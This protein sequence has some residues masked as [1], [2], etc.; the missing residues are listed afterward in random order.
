MGALSTVSFVLLVSGATT[1]L[2][3][4]IIWIGLPALAATLAAAHG[5]AALTRHLLAWQGTQIPPPA[6]IHTNPLTGAVQAS[7]VRWIRR[8]WTSPQRWRELLHGIVVFPLG[9]AGF[10][11]AICTWTLGLGEMLA[12]VW[13]P[14][15]QS[16]DPGSVTTLGGGIVHGF[17]GAGV[18]AS[19]A[20]GSST[21]TASIGFWA[22]VVD[23]VIGAGLLALTPL[24]LDGFAKLTG[25]LGKA[26]LGAAPF[27]LARRVR[28][29]ET[30]RMRAAHAESAAL[31]SMERDLHDGPQQVLIRVGMDLAAAERRLDRGE[32][33]SAR[34]LIGQA[35]AR[36][37]E[38]LT[39]LRAL[40]RGIAPPTL[41]ERGLVTA[42]SVA[43]A[44]STVPVTLVGN[45][46][47]ND[48]FTGPTETAIYFA[49]CELL[50]NVV[51]HSEASAVEV[52]LERTPTTVE[53]TVHDDGRGGARILPSR[54]L[55]GLADRVA[56]VDGTL[57]VIPHTEGE[58]SEVRVMVP[59][60]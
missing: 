51:K 40:A 46:G 14:I 25:T 42:M 57:E 58:G 34:D 29:L 30:S 1:S 17:D 49:F 22:Y 44:S 55:A 33:D 20:W 15:A 10:L 35:K 2:A 31:R 3:T 12:F 39:D 8:E 13:V 52:R 4:V 21:G 53:L 19:T 50:A 18:G 47:A 45:V 23:F 37:T 60:R 38:A 32:V 7:P 43:A 5:F 24:I 28:E 56:G 27:T 11:A 48:R 36:N 6:P 41:T 16:F 26:L 59:N 9:I 54:G